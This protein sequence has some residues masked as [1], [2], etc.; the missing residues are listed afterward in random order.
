MQMQGTSAVMITAGGQ[1]QQQQGPYFVS[2]PPRDPLKHRQAIAVGVILIILGCL[3]I[4]F[5]AIHIAISTGYY[6][7]HYYSDGRYSYTRS[8]FVGLGIWCGIVVSTMYSRPIIMKEPNLFCYSS[9]FIHSLKL[10]MYSSHWYVKCIGLTDTY[11]GC[12]IKNNPLRK[13]TYLV[14]GVI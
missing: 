13:L 5:N 14:N 4:L 11:T 2:S 8:G 7:Y 3:G 10:L 6:G 12:D 9:L 1:Q